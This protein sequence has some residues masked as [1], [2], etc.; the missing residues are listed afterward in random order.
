LNFEEIK[1]LLTD[2]FGAEIILGENKQT[3]Q[4]FLI[5]Q[6]DKIADVCQELFL[7]PLTYFDFLSCLTGLDNGPEAGTLEVIYHLYSIPYDHKL[8]LKI[9]TERNT[10]TGDL[11]VVPSVAT[12]WRTADWH[13]REAYDLVGIFF[14]GHPDLRRILCVADWEGHPLRRDYEWPEYYHGIKVRYDNHNEV[15]GFKGENGIS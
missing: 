12:I 11:P 10:P 5:I 9:I 3:A 6:T 8:I 7:N 13:E 14:S 2:K 1:S 15:N 4:P